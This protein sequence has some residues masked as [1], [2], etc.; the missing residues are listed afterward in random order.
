MLLGDLL[1]PESSD[2]NEHLTK[3]EARKA[4]K[5]ATREQRRQ[6]AMAG[7]GPI[8]YITCALCGRS[9]PLKLWGKTASFKVKP[10]YAI[11]TGRFGGGN[12]IGFFRDP[13][14]DVSWD[15]LSTDPRFKEIWKNLR[16]EIH[17]LND[18][19]TEIEAKT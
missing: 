11:I 13:N 16:T 5:E 4:E 3:R 8:W 19:V 12:K 1:D 9:R 6:K 14:S 18:L 2:M 7:A 10:D 17:A 15:M